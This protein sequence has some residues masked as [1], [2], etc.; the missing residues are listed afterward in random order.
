MRSKA[1][2]LQTAEAG[3]AMISSQADFE[4]EDMSLRA[5]VLQEETRLQTHPLHALP[6]FSFIDFH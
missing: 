1:S 6:I 4:T 3:D 2:F 5:G